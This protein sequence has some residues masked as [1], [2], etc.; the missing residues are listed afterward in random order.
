MFRGLIFFLDMLYIINVARTCVIQLASIS[1]DIKCHF[2]SSK[3]RDC[4]VWGL[5]F[6]DFTK[7]SEDYH[8]MIIKD[9]STFMNMMTLYD[10]AKNDNYNS[11]SGGKPV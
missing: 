11:A 6:K 5:N 1:S 2:V 8:K 3:A 7:T 9:H 10:K 4:T